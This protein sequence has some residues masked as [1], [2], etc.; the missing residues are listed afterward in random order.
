MVYPISRPASGRWWP[1]A[2][3]L[4]WLSGVQFVRDGDD[5][6]HL[7]LVVAAVDRPFVGPP[8]L[9]HGRVTESGVADPRSSLV[10]TGRCGRIYIV[11]TYGHQALERELKRGSTELLILALLEERDRHGYDL[12]R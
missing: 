3:L 6:V 5:C 12:A 4:D 10:L 8:S 2:Q 9:K 1:L 7:E 11:P